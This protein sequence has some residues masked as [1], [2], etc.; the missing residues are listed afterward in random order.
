MKTISQNNQKNGDNSSIN[1]N[2]YINYTNYEYFLAKYSMPINMPGIGEISMS[3]IVDLVSNVM[4]N[5]IANNIPLSNQQIHL[6]K[7]YNIIEIDAYQA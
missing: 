7:S 5:H 2:N 3:Y 4:H 1:T 6:L